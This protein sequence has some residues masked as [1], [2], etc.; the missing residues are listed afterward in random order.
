MAETANLPSISSRAAAPAT[1]SLGNGQYE[2]ARQVTRTVMRQVDGV[3]FHVS[4]DSAI[5]TGEELKGGRGGGAQYAPAD[6]AEVT[7]LATGELHLLIMN[8]VLRS[9]LERAYPDQSYVGK[10]FAIVGGKGVTKDGEPAKYK[11][12]KILELRKRD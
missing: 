11:T 6:L 9:E 1:I 8:T 7:D 3:P 2:V 4:I 5:Y 10:S 12:Y